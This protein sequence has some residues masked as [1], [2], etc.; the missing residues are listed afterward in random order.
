ELLRLEL[1]RQLRMAAHPAAKSISLLAHSSQLLGRGAE[2]LVIIV[3][4]IFARI[5]AARITAR[6]RISWGSGYVI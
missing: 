3:L 2:P 1:G 5:A 6:W 4:P